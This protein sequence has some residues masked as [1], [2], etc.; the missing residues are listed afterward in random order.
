MNTLAGCLKNT[1]VWPGDPSLHRLQD[2]SHP[3]SGRWEGIKQAL[4]VFFFSVMLMPC[5]RTVDLQCWA[6]PQSTAARFRCN[7]FTVYLYCIF[8]LFTIEGQEECQASGPCDLYISDTLF[9]VHKE[10]TL[11]DNFCGL[12]L[13]DTDFCL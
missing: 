13:R 9:C 3:G 12:S 2:G 5:W 8:E 10:R 6:C 4:H 1:A 7:T 11:R